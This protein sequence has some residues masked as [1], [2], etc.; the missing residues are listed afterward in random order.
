MPDTAIIYSK[1]TLE[2]NNYDL[3]SVIAPGTGAFRFV[4][5]LPAEKWVYEANSDYWDPELPYVD[6]LELLHV[7]AWSDRG[8][9]VLTDQADMSWNVAKET[10]DE[11]KNRPESVQVNK[12][13]NFGAYWCFI[14]N[15]EAPLDDPRVRRA[16][17]LGVSKQNLSA[18]YG[19]G[20]DTTRMLEAIDGALSVAQKLGL[21]GQAGQAVQQ[22]LWPTRDMMI[23]KMNYIEE[24]LTALK[25]IFSGVKN[26]SEIGRASGRERV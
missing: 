17:H 23:Q 6:G 26:N 7:P 19:G 18:A 25:R 8:T 5:Y 1:K 9:A 4:E 12:L 3:R 10:W 24:K 14:N 21:Q 22:I 13:A 2:E 11:G 15:R 20:T 16:I